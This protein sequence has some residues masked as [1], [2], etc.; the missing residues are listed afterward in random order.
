MNQPNNFN[1]GE[2]I[3]AE[4]QRVVSEDRNNSYGPADKDFA[5]TAGILNSLGFRFETTEGLSQPL[6][7]YH[8]PILMMAVKMSRLVH[9]PE[10]YHVDS[11]VDIAGYVKT[12]G[13]VHQ[14]NTIKA[15]DGSIRTSP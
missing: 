1:L 14:Q 5:R 11:L 7:N 12:A 6:Q 4:A 3:L 2:N 10:C 9:N 13:I 8:I 15:V